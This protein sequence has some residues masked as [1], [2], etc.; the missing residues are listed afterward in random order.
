[1]RD[2]PCGKQVVYAGLV[3]LVRVAGQRGCWLVEQW[4]SSLILTVAELRRNRK[5]LVIA[6]LLSVW[7]KN[8]LRVVVC[9]VSITVQILLDLLLILL[10]LLELL[11]LISPITWSLLTFNEVIVVID[12]LE[13]ITYK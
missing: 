11:V 3:A 6:V 7:R 4:L 1:M 13:Q 10:E 12:W 5:H 9:A 8:R 2:R